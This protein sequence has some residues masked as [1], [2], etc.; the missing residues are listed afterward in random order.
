MEK[1]AKVGIT[2]GD[3]NSVSY[4]LIIKLLQENRLCELCTP[5]LYGSPKVAAYYRKALSV[6]NFNLNAVK[7]PA[8]A[9]AKRTNIISC[10][11]DQVKVDLGIET[12]ESDQ[13]AMTALKYALNHLDKKEID[14]LTIAPQGDKSFALEESRSLPEYLAKRYDMADAMTVMVSKQMKIGFVTGYVPLKEVPQRITI[15]ALGKKLQVLND[16]LKNDFT[17]TKPKIA[18]LGLN[19]GMQGQNGGEET[20]VITP[21]IERARQHGI[22]AIGPFTADHFF[23]ERLYEKFDAVLA[24]YHDQGSIP[25]TAIGEEPG[26]AYVAG[27]PV[28][29]T[30]SLEGLGLDMVGQGVADEQG[31]RNALYLAMDIFAHRERNRELRQNPLP[32]YDVSSNSNESDLNVEQIEG[33]FSEP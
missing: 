17:L 23:G 19:P 26:I 15:K 16:S 22:M 8:E 3:V 25:F 30:F 4:E 13:A 7:T 5:I 12:P 24:M 21:A 14:V 11:D 31:L 20:E 9:N 32:R 27:L 28:V 29:C 1:K 10:V 6:E 2:H 33:V 18:V